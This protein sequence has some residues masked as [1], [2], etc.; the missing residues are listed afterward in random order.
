MSNQAAAQAHRREAAIL[1]NI[2]GRRDL[3]DAV[4]HDKA[5]EYY[6]RRLGKKQYEFDFPAGAEVRRESRVQ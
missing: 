5:A 1:R 3:L 4:R 6:E 2:G